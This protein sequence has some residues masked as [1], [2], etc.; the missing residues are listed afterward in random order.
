[1]ERTV[2]N[3]PNKSIKEGT[4]K[5]SVNI[6]PV[7]DI[8]KGDPEIPTGLPAQSTLYKLHSQRKCPK[9][10]YVV[11]YVGL[12]IDLDEW[13]SMY[14]EAKQASVERAQKVHRISKGR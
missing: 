6:L 4:S 8:K 11:P 5:R 13:G 7:K 14:E 2:N 12:V 3:I 1:M 10:I 9:A